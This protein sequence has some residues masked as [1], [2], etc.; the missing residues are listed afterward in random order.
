MKLDPGVYNQV[1]KTRED[2][3]D[4]HR[5]EGTCIVFILQPAVL[6]MLRN[7]ESLE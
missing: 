7:K 3:K 1:E 5:V 4:Y 2:W 6:Q